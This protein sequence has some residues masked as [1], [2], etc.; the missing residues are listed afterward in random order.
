MR[1]LL[2]VFVVLTISACGFRMAGKADLAPEFDRTHV[3]YSGSAKYVSSQLRKQ[4][5]ANEVDLTD[6]E[7]ANMIVHLRY[8]RAEKKILSVTD[9][10]RAREYELILDVGFDARN[11]EGEMLLSNQNIRLTRDFLF[12]INDVLGKSEEEKEIYREMR[13]DAARLI[14]YRLQSIGKNP[15]KPAGE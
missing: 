8:D 3:Y 5:E 12:D 10:G 14:V 7:D 2:L 1:T 15:E 13:K 9:S 6:K 11:A 4:L